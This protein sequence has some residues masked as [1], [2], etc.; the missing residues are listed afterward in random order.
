MFNTRNGIYLMEEIDDDCW[1]K[2]ILKYLI[3]LSNYYMYCILALLFY[4]LTG[5]FY[6]DLTLI[7][8]IY[9]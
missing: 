9:Y 3:G 2:I 8:S 4:L 7:S 6:F 5:I 1:N